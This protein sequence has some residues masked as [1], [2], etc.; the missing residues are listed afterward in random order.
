MAAGPISRDDL[1]AM[2]AM[3]SLWCRGMFDAEEIDLLR[4]AAK[5]DRQLD[6]HSFGRGDGEG[7]T[8]RLS[9]WNHP[10]DT[11]TACL[12]VAKPS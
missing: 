5:E 7:G 1:T 3:D 2:S 4:R 12:R 10:G 6:Q 8:V 9:L 11:S